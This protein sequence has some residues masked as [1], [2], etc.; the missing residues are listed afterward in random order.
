MFEDKE[1][2][3]WYNNKIYNPTQRHSKFKAKKK[4]TKRVVPQPTSFGK[5]LTSIPSTCFIIYFTR[6]DIFTCFVD[7]KVAQAG[8]IYIYHQ[9]N[10]II[11]LVSLW[12]VTLEIVL[13]EL[14]T[15]TMK[16]KGTPPNLATERIIVVSEK[17]PSKVS[18]VVR[19]LC[20]RAEI[21]L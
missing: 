12:L 21:Q 20:S 19:W 15:H 17:T 8:F 7:C 6:F 4:C 13:R 5:I 18:I 10:S 9:F 3:V 14:Y 2:D 16:R 1:L 11:I